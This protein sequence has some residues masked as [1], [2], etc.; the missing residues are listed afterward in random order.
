MDFSY[1]GRHPPAQLAAM[2]AHT[3]VPQENDQP[4]FLD[5]GANNHVT[6]ALENL[7]IQQQPY[8]GSTQVTVGN[9]EG[10]ADPQSAP[11]GSE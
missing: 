11:L 9:G 3:H 7:T 10:S 4:W 5:S 6:S 8:Q 2:A 1:Q